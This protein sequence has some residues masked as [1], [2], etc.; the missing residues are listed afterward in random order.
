MVTK[1]NI[2]MMELRNQPGTL[3]DRVFYR[4]ESFVVEKAGEARAVIVPIR[5]YQEM[6]Q[7]KQA[8]R[9][10]FWAMTQELQQAFEG[11]DSRKIESE[12]EQAIR[13][14]RAAKKTS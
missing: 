6:Q 9:E 1:N 3:L 4:G 13:E 11:V 14:V 2:S 7:R 10:R 12:I 8:A 5:D